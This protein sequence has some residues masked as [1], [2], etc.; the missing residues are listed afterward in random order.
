MPQAA[1]CALPPQSRGC[2]ARRHAPAVLRGGLPVPAVAAA[3][4]QRLLRR[5]V[6]AADEPRGGEEDA[7]QSSFVLL[8]L[9]GADLARCRCL[10]RFWRAYVDAAVPELPLV[11]ACIRT[12]P[13]DVLARISS[14]LSPRARILLRPTRPSLS[15]DGVHA[16]RLTDDA[17]ASV[18]RA[19]DGALRRL[20]LCGACPQS[21]PLAPYD[22]GGDDLFYEAETEGRETIT[23]DRVAALL[24]GGGDP[25]L[26]KEARR[27]GFVRLWGTRYEEG[28]VQHAA[29]RLIP[30]GLHFPDRHSALFLDAPYRRA[31][32][33]QYLWQ[34][35]AM[36]ADEGVFAVLRMPP[37]GD[38]YALHVVSLPPISPSVFANLTELVLWSPVKCGHLAF[39]PRHARL[40]GAACASRLPQLRALSLKIVAAQLVIDDVKLAEGI[41]KALDAL[42]SLPACAR[43]ALQLQPVAR[44]FGVIGSPPCAPP[45]LRRLCAHLRSA[46]RGGPSIVYLL[47]GRCRLSAANIA[48]IASAVAFNHQASPLA[49]LHLAGNSVSEA[50]G[51]ALARALWLS[52]LLV[53]VN[54]SNVFSTNASTGLHQLAD[55][56]FFFVMQEAAA[57][58]A[59]SGPPVNLAMSS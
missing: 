25:Y 11:A 56:G 59:A 15:F 23:A 7:G 54:V 29:D 2:G 48:R 34:R 50:A 4:A 9:S 46:G 58:R 12:F 18:V 57:K 39:L 41:N 22:Y 16:Q 44:D 30:V 10:S 42:S 26:S 3:G 33:R 32:S 6:A 31:L 24:G 53:D 37:H 45:S 13:I 17:L 5:A 51:Q 55:P 35:W 49:G 1:R 52:P 43:V 27:L 20:D 8:R 14:F 28:E 40:L 36:D 21:T 47:A 38:E 19:T